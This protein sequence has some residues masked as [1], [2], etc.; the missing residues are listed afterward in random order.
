MIP[1]QLAAASGNSAWMLISAALVLLMTPALALF[2]GGLS[3]K[4]SVLNMMMMSFGALGVVCVVYVLWG[5][6][7][8][9]G[10][11]SWGGVAAN[12]FEFFGLRDSITDADG[13]YVEGA[14]GYANVIDI[15][16][17][18]TFAVIS[19]AI[20]SGALLGRVK[21]GTW[22]AFSGL[23]ATFV[24]FPLAHMV[25]GGGLL[26]HAERSLSSWIF[27][28][29]TESG[30][31]TAAVAPVDFAGGTVVHISAGTAA[32]VLAIVVGK[33]AGWP[34]KVSR[35]HNLPMVMTGAALLFFGWFGFNGG[36]A[37]AADGLAG[38]A[39]LN[40]A[41]ATAAAMLG[42]MAVEAIRD[43]AATSLGAASGVVA[44]LVAITP[45]AGALTPATSLILGGIGGAVACLG[46]GLKYTFGFDDSL[47]AVGVHLVAGLWGTI[48]LALFA[49]EGG[50]LTDDAGYGVKLL[51]IQ[52]VIAVVAMVF[53]GI[54]TLVI[55]LA[56]KYTLGWRIED[57]DE[58]T[59][60]DVSEHRESGYDLAAQSGMRAPATMI[61]STN[62]ST[63]PTIPPRTDVKE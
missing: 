51:I 21:F 28:T 1:D 20:I 48:G 4:R 43:K 47:D 3:D 17:Q 18:L 6:S 19:T 9:Y 10:T 50:L 7:M 24:Y 8:S 49:S 13:N 59:G 32:L 2:Y 34:T 15:G 53:A 42:W 44:G 23:W 36:S 57:E 16:F 14:S 45:A 12:P 26:S 62:N 46:V 58:E 37:F 30:E 56:L 38:L 25:W 52:T 33:R 5:W 11:Q 41:A 29:V 39:W 22:L 27:G 55:A 60:V 61:G 31:T 54:V 40:T 35:P 63:A